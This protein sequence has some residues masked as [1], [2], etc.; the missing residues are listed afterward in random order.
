MNCLADVDRIGIDFSQ[1]TYD[2]GLHM[3]VYGAEKMSRYFGKILA[4]VPGVRDKRAEPELSAK[5]EEKGMYYDSMKAEQ[6]EE[7]ARLGYIKQF[8]TE[9]E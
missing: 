1:D 7:F 6:E 9:E 4:E 3:N 2:G 8:Y 5:W